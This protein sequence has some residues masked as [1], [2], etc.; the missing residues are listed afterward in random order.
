MC[1][2]ISFN[3]FVK[4]LLDILKGDDELKEKD[5]RCAVITG[6]RALIL[7]ESEPYLEVGMRDDWVID[8]IA[9]SQLSPREHIVAIYKDLLDG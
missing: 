4:K 6:I 8:S 2:F 7:M 1:Y 5:R 3:Y 9:I